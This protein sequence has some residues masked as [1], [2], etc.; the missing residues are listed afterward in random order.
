MNNLQRLFPLGLLPDGTVTFPQL[1]QLCHSHVPSMA[2]TFFHSL[3]SH[4]SQILLMLPVQLEK[5]MFSC[6]SEL[7][8]GN[9]GTQE[10]SEG[11]EG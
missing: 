3:P 10:E 5:G 1:L 2:R 7:E 11:R 8:K 9:G 4:S 6:V